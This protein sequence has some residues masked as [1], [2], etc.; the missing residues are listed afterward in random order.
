[1]VPSSDRIV[2][3]V[4][5]VAP[6]KSSHDRSRSGAFGAA[7]GDTPRDMRA[8]QDPFGTVQDDHCQLRCPGP[9]SFGGIHWP[10]SCEREA[11]MTPS[12]FSEKKSPAENPEVQGGRKRRLEQL[13]T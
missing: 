9:G 10:H 8:R 6:S 3:R 2:Q 5:E 1:M 7:E 4:V 13:L 11:A 12:F